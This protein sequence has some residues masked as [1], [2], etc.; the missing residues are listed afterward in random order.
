[1]QQ[2]WLIERLAY[3]ISVLD[4]D[5]NL[6]IEQLNAIKHK[7]KDSEIR[8]EYSLTDM[9]SMNTLEDCCNNVELL[10]RKKVSIIWII[11]DISC[12][13]W[14]NYIVRSVE[15]TSAGIEIR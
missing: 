10:L 2:E 11:K 14:I 3:S 9:Q 5:F 6:M 15:Q 12:S 4:W 1:M 7:I 13:L 8:E